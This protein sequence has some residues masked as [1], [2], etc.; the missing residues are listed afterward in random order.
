[1]SNVLS[2]IALVFAY[3]S[4]LTLIILIEPFLKFPLYGTLEGEEITFFHH[5]FFF[6]LGHFL[7]IWLPQKNI[8]LLLCW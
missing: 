4:N 3:L 5:I 8:L 7:I 6:K 1:M 2:I